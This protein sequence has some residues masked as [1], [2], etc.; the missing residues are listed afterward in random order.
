MPQ[1][2]ILDGVRRAVA[3][4]EASL[5]DIPATIFDPGKSPVS[6]RIMLGEL[7]SPKSFIP[8]DIRYIRNVEYPTQVLKTE[9][10][11]IF[12]EP[13]GLPGQ[14]RTTPLLQVVLQQRENHDESSTG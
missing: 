5:M 10:P 2:F 8:R 9:P 3:T 1:Y 14:G 7:H 13:L 6:K 12:V 11:P 4:R